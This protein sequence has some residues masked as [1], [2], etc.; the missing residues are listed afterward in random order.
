MLSKI[1]TSTGILAMTILFVSCGGETTDKEKESEE[2][3]REMVNN[4][5]EP[6]AVEQ[7]GATDSDVQE[8]LDQLRCFSNREHL[9]R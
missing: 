5:E 4:I 9:L 7:V 1:I 8:A 2:E 6:T 3:T